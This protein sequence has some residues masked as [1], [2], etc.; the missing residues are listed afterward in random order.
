MAADDLTI[1][2]G[3]SIAFAPLGFD[4]VSKGS[5]ETT[6][7]RFSLVY[8]IAAPDDSAD[9]VDLN[10]VAPGGS[11]TVRG[12]LMQVT[13]SAT[14]TGTTFSADRVV[15]AGNAGGSEVTRVVALVE[16]A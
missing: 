11:V 9:Y 6:T 8:I 3:T 4:L 1:A 10:D 15:F 2:A 7:R 16:H 13:V 12:I 14:D 5:S